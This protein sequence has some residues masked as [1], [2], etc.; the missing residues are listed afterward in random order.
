MQT[1]ADLIAVKER[2]ARSVNLDRDV[3]RV[4]PLDGYIVTDRARN[5]LQQIAAVAATSTS[6]GAWSL[7]GPYGSGKSSLAILIDSAFGPPSEIRNISWDSIQEVS[8]EIVDLIN[9]AHERYDTFETGFYRGLV[10]ANQESVC[11]TVLRG[12]HAAVVHKFGKIPPNSK[13]RMAKTLRELIRNT[14]TDVSFN[15]I[16]PTALLEIAKCVAEESPLLLII[17]EFGKNLEAI[18]NDDNNDPYL[19]QQ[20]AEL[21]QSPESPI[22]FITLQ[23]QSYEDYF[24]RADTTRRREWN[25]VRGRF[26]EISY[27]ESSGQS[28]ELIASV[29]DI[30]N[31]KL[32]GKVRNWAKTQHR[33]LKYSDITEFE[34]V[35]SISDC[36]PLHPLTTLVLPELCS[37]FGQHERTMFSFLASAH[38]SSVTTFLKRTPSP[39]RYSRLPSVGLD[40]VYDFFVSEN[41][42]AEFSSN[43][44]SRWI[45][46]VARLRD[47]HGLSE[48]ELELVKS[49]AVLNLISTAGSIRASLPVLSLVNS[50]AKRIIERLKS[51]GLVNY[52]EFADEYRIWHGSDVDID[53]LV[54]H[55]YLREQQIPLAEILRKSDELTPMI[56]ARHSAQ[57]ETL[58]V[59]SRRFVGDKEPIDPLPAFSQYDGEI[60]YVVGNAT[61]SVQIR[62]KYVKPVVAVIPKNSDDLDRIAREVVALT[63]VLNEEAVKND[64]VA[65]SE[66]EERLAQ[67]KTVLNN[68][69]ESTFC[70]SD[71]SWILITSDSSCVLPSGQGSAPLSAAADMV[72]TSTP[73]FRNEMINR[74]TLSTQGA[75]ARRNLLEAMITNETDSQLGLVGYGPEVAMYKAVLRNTGIHRSL[76]ETKSFTICKPSEKSVFEAWKTIE[77]AFSTAKQERVNVNDIFGILLSPP[78]GMKLGVASVIFTAALIA[79]R[80]KIAIYEHGTFKPLLTADLSERMVKNPNQFEIKHFANTTGARRKVIKKLERVFELEQGYKT[81]RVSNVLTIVNHLVSAVRSLNKFARGTQ[82]LTPQ[83]IAVRDCLT[84]A[85]E[86]DKL[87]FEDLPNAVNLSTISADSKSYKNGRKYARNIKCAIDELSR[88]YDELLSRIFSQ[89]LVMS[90]ESSRQAISGFAASLEHEVLNPTI[91]SLAYALADDHSNDSNW[92]QTVATVVSKKAPTEWTD[93]DFNQFRYTLSEQIGSFRRLVFL[94]FEHRTDGGGEFRP[95]RITVTAP[96][97]NEF[98]DMVSIDEEMRIDGEKVLQDCI[99]KLVEI[100]GSSSRAQT[101]LLALLG[102]ELIAESNDS[103]VTPEIERKIRRVVSG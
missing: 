49:V 9:K 6:G 103:Q 54:I 81:H 64:W 63:S 79:Y 27:I 47:A 61:P 58:R 96:D 62:N 29:F 43:Q 53:N 82:E 73:I 102:G 40:R 52:R 45:E 78:I 57:R 41:T 92:A 35:H 46:I 44:T 2:F 16:S 65:R 101:V 88:C 51:I 100:C 26:N 84:N 76:G 67:R 89:I 13:F 20:I 37:R 98:V 42:L 7:T 22:F 70:N 38:M 4:E 66:L 60:L 56:A 23:H 50:S 10:T 31:E 32:I 55:A 34:T 8:P 85:V 33:N 14:Q 68:T 69:I 83:T 86:P 15:S 74:T 21:G 94:H 59:F 87:I 48:R 3:G 91:N 11:K 5:V 77:Q 30:T 97:G 75:K 24:E 1:L 12:L 36:Y 17:D 28:R 39:D 93:N 18:R 19:L 99:E 72:Y 25:K 71:A 90:R 80:N 95:V